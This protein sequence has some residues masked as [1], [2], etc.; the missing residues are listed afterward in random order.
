[1]A[2]PAKNN[3]MEFFGRKLF[4]GDEGLLV[5]TFGII[6]AIWLMPVLL[7]FVLIDNTINLFKYIYNKIK[8]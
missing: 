2:Q 7:S 6:G 5:M 4:K 8:G 1:M 3:Y